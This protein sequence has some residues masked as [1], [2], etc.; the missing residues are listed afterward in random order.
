M[1]HSVLTRANPSSDRVDKKVTS[2]VEG[3]IDRQWWIYERMAA[4]AI[5]IS[6]STSAGSEILFRDPSGR[7]CRIRAKAS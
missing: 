2:S 1:S 4:L 5:A 6:S 7:K 3:R